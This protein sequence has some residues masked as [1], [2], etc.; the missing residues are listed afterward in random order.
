MGHERLR[1]RAAT[2]RKTS[3]RETHLVLELAE[4]MNREVRRLLAAVGPAVT[5][6]RRVQI[7]G[8]ALGNLAPGAWRYLQRAEI[9]PSVP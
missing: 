1:A 5:R 6:L 7:G 4:G 9:A 3:G 8:I 2:I